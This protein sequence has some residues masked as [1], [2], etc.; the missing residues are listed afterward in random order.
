MGVEV[1]SRQSRA[2]DRRPTILPGPD[3]RAHEAIILAPQSTTIVP[4]RVPESSS[5]THEGKPR[6]SARSRY[7][8]GGGLHVPEEA[9]RVVFDASKRGEKIAEIPVE[10]LSRR[11]V[12]LLEGTKFVRFYEKNG[13]NFFEGPDLEEIIETQKIRLTGTP[14]KDWKYWFPEDAA[15]P[16]GI[17]LRINPESRRWIPPHPR[18]EPI[19]L[20]DTSGAEFNYREQLKDALR[21]APTIYP[22]IYLQ[23][24]D[25]ASE[26]HLTP[27]VQGWIDVTLPTHG[28]RT[29]IDSVLINP[30]STKWYVVLENVV[31]DGQA[32]D[33]V[34]FKFSRA[35]LLQ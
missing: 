4:V 5:L 27:S 28:N 18:N 1:R 13:D 12:K 21:P 30:E 8:Q 29:H 2:F 35:A 32:P 3:I 7:A 19:V 25:T 9:A 10:V 16:A 17:E 15:E 22:H 14:G 11:P 6:F 34:V 20:D 26:V 23:I 33:S 31:E 24:A